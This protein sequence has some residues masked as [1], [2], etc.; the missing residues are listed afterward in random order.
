MQIPVQSQPIPVVI[1]CGGKGSRLKEETEFRPKPMVT[2]GGK[3]ILWHIMKGYSVCGYNHFILCL[4]YKGYMIKDYFL[5]YRAFTNDF[6]LD[7]GSNTLT[8]HEQTNGDNFKIT[9]CDTGEDTLTGERLIKVLKYIP[10]NQFMATYGDGVSNIDIRAL[11]AFHNTKEA[12]H[13][14]AGTITGVHPKSK[15]GLIKTNGDLITEF[16]QKPVLQEYT[17]GGFMVFNASFLPYL[18]KGHMIEDAI[19]EATADGKLALYA[20]DSAWHSMD[21]YQDMEE[22]NKQWNA[23]EAKWKTW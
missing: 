12:A 15:Y 18:K 17:N 16:K 10:T 7:T 20:H 22:L 9:F 23:G 11:H 19:I 21:T 3:P 4:G 2:I 13:S 8:V 14:I 5:N 1:F 6:H